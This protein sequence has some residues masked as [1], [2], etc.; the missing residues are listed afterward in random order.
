MTWL[1]FVDKATLANQIL[2]LC[3]QTSKDLQSKLC[4]YL[5]MEI[6]FAC[7]VCAGHRL[8]ALGVCD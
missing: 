2:Q 5:F 8:R 4:D 1:V 6:K 3:S 7:T